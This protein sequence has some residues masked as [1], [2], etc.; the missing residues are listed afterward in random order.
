M[1]NPWTFSEGFAALQGEEK[2]AKARAKADSL[3]GD[4]VKKPQ[5]QR[6]SLWVGL[7]VRRQYRCDYTDLRST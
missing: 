7:W 1:K 2:H 4:D 6:F 3:T 5:H